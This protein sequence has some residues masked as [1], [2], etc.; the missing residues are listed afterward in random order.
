VTNTTP[1]LDGH[2]GVTIRSGVYTY[3]LD[4]DRGANRVNGYTLSMQHKHYG[5]IRSAYVR[6]C[7]SVSDRSSDTLPAGLVKGDHWSPVVFEGY[8]GHHDSFLRFHNSYCCEI[9]FG[10]FESDWR[11]VGSDKYHP[12]A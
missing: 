12:R 4:G 10:A 8:I 11:S 2:Q 3:L 6:Q 5:R 1:E 7:I 9:C